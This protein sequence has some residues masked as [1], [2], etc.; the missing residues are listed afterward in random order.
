MANLQTT[1]FN[2]TDYL[3]LPAGTDAQRP[4]PVTG[5][6]RYNNTSGTALLEFYDG[7]NWRPITGYSQGTVGT[8]GNSINYSNCGI[9]H[10]YTSGGS[11]TPAFT[12]N[13]QVLVV[14]GGGGSVNSS[15]RGGGGG[16]G[17]IYQASFPV[18]S[19]TPYGV[20]VGDGG[21][22]GNGQNSVFGSLT[23]IGGGQ[24]GRWNNGS[25][26]PGGSGGGGGNGDT[27]SS[28]G[29]IDPGI[30]NTSGQ[31]FPG[32][33]GKRFNES[34]DNCHWGGG[35]GGAGGVGTTVPDHRTSPLQEVQGGAGAATDILGN[36]LYFGGGGAGGAHHGGGHCNGGIGGGGGGAV[37]HAS[38]YPNRP[39]S[40]YLGNG[41]GQSLNNGQPAQNQG[42]G[43]A[44]GTNTGGGGGG[45]DN[46]GAG[47]SGVVIV[48]Y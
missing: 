20:T 21:Q 2:G 19:G 16:G 15:W 6:M 36:I 25:G 26:Q 7:T 30:G 9:V 45:A 44:G 18:T 8:G 34:G 42:K 4:T 31:G 29:P 32:G 14:G 24:G 39:G 37:H 22:D 28:R 41:G 35:G 12:G 43:G 10:V 33:S 27:D 5:M 13:V 23:A 48:R 17:F 40:G 3:T 1:I 11:F 47:G 38:P 46:G